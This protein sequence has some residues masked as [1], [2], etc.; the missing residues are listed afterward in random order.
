MQTKGQK[1][2]RRILEAAALLF[3][4]QGFH[5]ISFK[6]IADKAALTQPAIYVHFKDISDIL[7]EVCIMSA[8]LGR[9]FIDAHLDL[10]TDARTQFRSYLVGNIEWAFK[11]RKEAYAL[12]TLYYLSYNDPRLLALHA[13][14]NEQ[15]YERVGIRLSAGVREGLWELPKNEIESTARAI[16]NFLIGEMIKTLLWPKELKISERI[17]LTYEYSMRLI[18]NSRRIHL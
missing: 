11:K 5:N 18:R 15:S 17:N 6:N 13:K 9:H 16:Q 14:I 4:E 10:S 1:T 3:E 8:E 2:R 7:Y 12:L